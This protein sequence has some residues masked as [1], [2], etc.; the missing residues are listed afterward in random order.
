MKLWLRL[1]FTPLEFETLSSSFPSSPLRLL[2][3][4]PLEFE[5]SRE[6]SVYQVPGRLKFT[7]LEFETNSRG[8]KLEF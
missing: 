1:K 3:F 4:T 8:R 7:P 6:Y 5:T 2:K